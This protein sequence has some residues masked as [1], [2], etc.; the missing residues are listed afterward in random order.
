M[1]GVCGAQQN[2]L[3]I[4][5]RWGGLEVLRVLPQASRSPCSLL[6][7]RL[8]PLMPRYN[9]HSDSRLH[10]RCTSC[11]HSHPRPQALKNQPPSSLAANLCIDRMLHQQKQTDPRTLANPIHAYR[12]VRQRM[13]RYGKSSDE[14]RKVPVMIRN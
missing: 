11:C 2:M 3:C 1:C 7:V 8:H 4:L 12:L 13:Y 10:R 5:D 9:H 14:V 6:L